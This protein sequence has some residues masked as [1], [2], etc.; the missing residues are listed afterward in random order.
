MDEGD[1]ADEDVGSSE[2]PSSASVARSDR[3]AH[4]IARFK[5]LSSHVRNDSSNHTTGSKAESALKVERLDLSQ[6]PILV[7]Q[8]RCGEKPKFLM[9]FLLCLFY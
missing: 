3:S 9:S 7:N 8:L 5:M 6:V 2:L 4:D 1:A